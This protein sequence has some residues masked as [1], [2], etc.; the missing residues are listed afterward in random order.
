[1]KQWLEYG[2]SLVLLL[3]PA[4]KTQNK[5]KETPVLD[6]GHAPVQCMNPIAPEVAP[7][8]TVD[9]VSIPLDEI[10]LRCPARAP[11]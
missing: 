2:A 1:M 6:A 8:G 3:A 5:S 4:C 9:G 11:G 7:L 10:R